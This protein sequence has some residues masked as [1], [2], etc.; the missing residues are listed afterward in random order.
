MIKIVM[1]GQTVAVPEGSTLLDA[2]KKLDILIPTLCYMPGYKPFSSCMVCLVKELK[3][4][5]HLPACSALAEEGMVIQTN[6]EEIIEARKEALQLLVYE[7]AGEC[8][9]PCQ[10]ACPLGLQVPLV[11]M[12]LQSGLY[13]KAELYLTQPLM[14][15]INR[16]CPAPCEK[17]CRR[18]KV[19]QA[20]LIQ[21]VFRSLLDKK[22][23][24]VKKRGQ[25][26]GQRKYKIAVAGTEPPGIMAAAVLARAGYQCDIVDSENRFVKALKQI[27]PEALLEEELLYL[28]SCGVRFVIRNNFER[29]LAENEFKALFVT[30]TLN[31]GKK[32]LALEDERIFTFSVKAPSVLKPDNIKSRL[33]FI[34]ILKRAREETLNMIEV[35]E[36][37]ENNN[38]HPDFQSL[39]TQL[40]PDELKEFVDSAL[41]YQAALNETGQVSPASGTEDAFIKKESSRCLLCGCMKQED[42]LLRRMAGMHRIKS[43]Y[44]QDIKRPPFKRY[45]FKGI[46]FEPGKCIKCGRCVEISEKDPFGFTFLERGSGLRV[47]LPF[48]LLKLDADTALQCALAC[49]TGALVKLNNRK[50]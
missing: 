24:T 18:R 36:G 38:S 27:V 19:D 37:N 45:F 15:I 5:K 10:R 48:N 26:K 17:T 33:D 43:C 29:Y 23:R 4:G 9:S 28:K 11:F 42:C 1:D 16:I 34:K 25:E 46:L 39:L 50:G 47:G 30:T 32:D 14:R 2:A 31:H 12:M 8:E 35:L 22:E 49:P 20:V 44:S 6:S 40:K 13:A 7:H 41:V 3:T 21:E